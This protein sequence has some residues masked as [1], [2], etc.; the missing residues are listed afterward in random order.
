MDTSTLSSLLGVIS[1]SATTVLLVVIAD[2]VLSSLGYSKLALRRNV[3]SNWLAWIPVA[4][5]WLIGTLADHYDDRN[6]IKRRFRFFL[7]IPQ[8][9]KTAILIPVIVY[10]LQLAPYFI[11]YGFELFTYSIQNILLLVPFVFAAL[12]YAIVQVIFK[13]CYTVAIYKVF[14]STVPERALVYSVIGAIIP[15]TNSAFVFVSR[16]SGY[17]YFTDAEEEEETEEDLA[18]L[19]EEQE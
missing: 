8:L 1:A 14:E 15:V 3:S 17:D 4:R 18:E 12:G 5:Y 19:V 6:G 16:D 10:A 2:Y 9:I 7:L 13:I 11:E